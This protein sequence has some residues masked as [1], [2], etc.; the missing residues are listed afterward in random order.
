M[1]F[2][3]QIEFTNILGKFRQKDVCWFIH[4]MLF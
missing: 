3:I 1:H 4:E 2:L